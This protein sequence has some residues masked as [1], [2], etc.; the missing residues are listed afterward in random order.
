MRVGFGFVLVSVIFY[1]DYRF[2]DLSKIEENGV[3]LN[4][5]WIYQHSYNMVNVDL[6]NIL[7]EHPYSESSEESDSSD[8]VSTSDSES[9]DGDEESQ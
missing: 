7:E 4:E 8:N 2:T 1:I 6:E 5:G 9:S 3:D